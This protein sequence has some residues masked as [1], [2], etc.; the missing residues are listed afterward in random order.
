MKKV[1]KA[2]NL[3][4]VITAC[5]ALL[6]LV[7]GVGAYEVGHLTTFEALALCGAS[8]GLLWASIKIYNKVQ[9]KEN[10]E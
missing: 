4:T 10:E 6:F 2:I 7:G 9:E 1:L 5:I 8:C 3:T